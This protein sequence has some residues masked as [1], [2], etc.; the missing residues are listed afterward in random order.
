M[1]FNK[2]I[3]TAIDRELKDRYRSKK[4]SKSLSATNSL[5]APNDFFRKPS[6]RRIYNPN[7]RYFK[8][9][10]AYGPGDGIK[11]FLRNTNNV[12]L[13]AGFGN[14]DTGQ[15][16][17]MPY[18]GFNSVTTFDRGRKGW[19]DT[20]LMTGYGKNGLAGGIDGTYFG[21]FLGGN[22][23]FHGAI[24][25][26]AFGEKDK[27]AGNFTAGP[28][29]SFGRPNKELKRG[30]GKFS[31]MPF[32]LRV[33]LNKDSNDAYQIYD[34]GAQNVLPENLKKRGKENFGFNWG[35]GAKAQG[36][37][38]PKNLPLELFGEAQYN[39][40][41]VK[42]MSQAAGETMEFIDGMEEEDVGAAGT[43]KPEHNWMIRA[44]VRVPLDEINFNRRR[45]NVPDLV[46]EDIEPVYEIP[47]I[48]ETTVVEE[49]PVVE[50]PP[51]EKKLK[52]PKKVKPPKP[53]TMVRHPRWLQDG[54]YIEVDLT[55]E[56]ALKYAQNGYVV[57]ELENNG[58]GDPP[59]FKKFLGEES[60][61]FT[62]KNFQDD[63]GYDLNLVFP[64]GKRRPTRF[65]YDDYDEGKTE[66]TKDD[67]RYKAIRKELKPI[68]K[69]EFKEQ[70]LDKKFQREDYYT[71]NKT[72]KPSQEFLDRVQY[73]ADQ[74]AS[75]NTDKMGDTDALV[76]II[77][78]DLNL[79]SFDYSSNSGTKKERKTAKRLEH[80]PEWYAAQALQEKDALGVSMPIKKHGGP[81]DPPEKKSIILD[82]ND[83]NYVYKD[84][85]KRYGVDLDSISAE[86]LDALI[87]NQQEINN[88]WKNQ[89]EYNRTSRPTYWDIR[90]TKESGNPAKFNE[91]VKKLSKYHTIPGDM[92]S[93]G[94]IGWEDI[95]YEGDPN[96]RRDDYPIDLQN[97]ILDNASDH[98][99]YVP[100]L[101]T[102]HGAMD[103]K[104]NYNEFPLVR[105][106]DRFPSI[107]GKS[108]YQNDPTVKPEGGKLCKFCPDVSIP[109]Y[110]PVMLARLQ[111]QK[112]LDDWSYEETND[113]GE[114]E[115][116][117]DI[118]PGTAKSG[119]KPIRRGFQ[120]FRGEKRRH[121]NAIQKGKGF[122]GKNKR[123]KQQG[124]SVELGDEVDEATMQRLK[125]LGYTF[126]EI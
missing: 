124:G 88:Y 25:F 103:K 74:M 87:K 43:L 6:T 97:F 92:R 107:Q 55:Q 109:Q 47:P 80:S 38:R 93:L 11:K 61:T 42:R 76:D 75:G 123:I 100:Q 91:Y 125:K 44:G 16:N 49:K 50:E 52:K 96:M 71:G 7:A 111:N 99:S 83:P 116:P 41:L 104:Q 17:L 84:Y 3:L 34:Y 5:F 68:I 86:D 39:A 67:P 85:A 12:S 45:R 8:K 72:Y 70:K 102:T 120:W 65:G 4:Y 113:I 60:G 94:S 31:F 46:E 108:Y 10:G 40:N 58:L 24:D 115:V 22:R 9:G 26:S 15:K 117:S 79:N 23:H 30:R 33:G 21:P 56:D 64:T 19:L 77:R 95:T 18:L 48:E 82:K 59:S 63:E 29:F 98:V 114:I 73:Q 78:K 110:D 27:F 105:V 14:F 121:N 53:G 32:G 89:T 62:T 122:F 13:G 66:I 106:D 112:T 51:V 37:Y 28:N 35:Y 118:D 81:H 69:E 119:Y 20:E 57:E 1:G 36:A 126:E 90:A 2:R 101:D 54:G